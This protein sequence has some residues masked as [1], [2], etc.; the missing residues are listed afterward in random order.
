MPT[1]QIRVPIGQT[2]MANGMA[3]TLAS[4]QS[5][6]PVIDTRLPTA[7]GQQAASAS[8]G[9]TL[10]NENVQDL[11][12]IGQSAQTAIINNIIPVTA[13]STATDATGY[14]S[15][16]CQIISTATGGSF[17]FEGSNDNVNFQ[18]IPVFSQLILTGTP[19]I[20]SI[21]PTAT[22]LIYVG[23]LNVRYIRVRIA[24]T[25]LGGS[26]QAFTKLMQTPY[27]P[28]VTQVAQNNS[29][30]LNANIGSGTITT[31]STLSQFIGSA[32]GADGTAN[33][34]T[35][36]VRGFNM[37]FTGTTWDR[38]YNNLEATLL[39]SAARITT[40]T[41]ADIINYNWKKLRVVLDM[42]V[43]GTGSVTVT[44]NG[45]DAASGKYILLLAGAAVTT[46][47][48]NVYKVGEALAAVANLI[49]QDYLPRIIQIVVTANNANSATYSVG[50]N[51]GS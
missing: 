25:I 28:A 29:A 23:A 43:V 51:F 8:L 7:L 20:A 15:F 35:T 46:N 34:T 48:T 16:S 40:Q 21:V 49:A 3:V 10:S 41:S 33:P 36:G 38:N 31:V 12:I 6:V 22:Q 1:T 26:I 39:A 24:T 30:N 42:T 19:I 11:Y 44:I 32:A 47:S 27:T 37:L 18:T 50:Y 4:D 45:K 9:V 14:R 17:I 2:T 13:V 5:A